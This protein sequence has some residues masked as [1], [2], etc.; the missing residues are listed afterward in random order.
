MHALHSIRRVFHVKHLYVFFL[1]VFVVGW[2]G[3]AVSRSPITGRKRA[4]AYTW[5]QEI[6]LGREAD[7]QIIAQYGLYDDPELQAYLDRVAQR[8]LAESHVRRPDADEEFRNTPFTFRIL[9]SPVVNAFALPGG[10]VYVTRGLMSYMENE[11]QLA[12]VLGHE[13]GHVEARHASQQALQQQLGQIGLLGGAIIGQEVL[14]LPAQDI[15]NVAGTATQLLFLKY[16]RD[17][18]R[19]SDQLGVEYAALAGYRAEEGAAFFQTLK[20]ISA[21][22][23]EAIPTF[24]SSH[25]DPGEREQTIVDLAAQWESRTNMTTVNQDEL[26][27][28]LEGMVVGENPRHG[29]VQN[30]VFYHPDLRFRFPV[31]SGYQLVNQARQVVMLEPNQQAIMIFTIAQQNSARAA[32]EAFAGQQ[33]LQVVEN[34]AARAGD[35]PAYYLVADAQTQQGQTV[36]LLSYYVEYGGAVYQFLAYTPQQ[37]FSN[38]Q[39]TFLGTMRGFAPLTEASMLNV[40]PVR[41]RIVSAPRTAPFR[42]FVNEGELPPGFDAQEMAILNQVDADTSIPQGRPLKLTRR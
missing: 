4:Y 35:L 6:Q 25:P 39:N 16:G 40:Q 2:A 29:F 23:G 21:R 9:D 14:N 7:Q 32:A 18:E 24:L 15:L 37:V 17:D 26:Y 3:C 38:F 13:I 33:G 31:P 28:A 34:G 1:L 27:A 11:A 8:V 41:M 42:T 30:G 36:R 20:R 22:Q 19:E 10:F 5:Q 12:V